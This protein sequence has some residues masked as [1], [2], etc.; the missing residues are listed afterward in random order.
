MS[1]MRVARCPDA[2][3]QSNIPSQPQRFCIVLKH[4]NVL[5]TSTRR[6]GYSY[7]SVISTG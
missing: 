2:C 7:L 4:I 5:Y 3:T 1:K 6:F